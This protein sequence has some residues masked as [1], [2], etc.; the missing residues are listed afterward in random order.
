MDFG[1]CSRWNDGDGSSRLVGFRD[2]HVCSFLKL[3]RSSEKNEEESCWLWLG[4]KEKR[5]A[6]KD[7]SEGKERIEEWR[8]WKRIGE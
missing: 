1:G 7:E 3:Y 2:S 6:S 8:T 5:V 4:R